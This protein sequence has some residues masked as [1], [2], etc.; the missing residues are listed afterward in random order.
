MIKMTRL[1]AV[2]PVRLAA[3]V[4][5]SF[6]WLRPVVADTITIDTATAAW[7]VSG[8]GA[9]NATPFPNGSG[10]S[11]TSNTFQSGTFVSGGSAANFDGFWTA[12]LRF[13]L[14]TDAT[15][16]A[17]DFSSL[18]AD[19]RAIVELNGNTIASVGIFGPGLGQMVFN[20]GG[21]LIDNVSFAGIPDSGSANS[22]FI[23]GA[24]NTLLAIVNDTGS[25]ITGNLNN[26][27]S[28]ETIFAVNG[29]ISYDIPSSQVPEPRL[30]MFSLIAG[31]VLLLA[32]RNLGRQA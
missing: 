16:V 4:T 7:T 10:I 1:I 19:D 29:T 12:R 27:H 23:L 31:S 21:S 8:G 2:S 3:M 5:L 6:C 32:H 17:L 22:G 11:I 15:N 13:F 26:S 28:F 9:T 30:G 24:T 25:G 14:P 20:D 18:Q